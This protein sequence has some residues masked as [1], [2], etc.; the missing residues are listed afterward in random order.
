MN[1]IAWIGL[2]ISGIGFI[3]LFDPN[4]YVVDWLTH[5]SLWRDKHIKYPY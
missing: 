5:R 3:I 4:A 2:V 1:I